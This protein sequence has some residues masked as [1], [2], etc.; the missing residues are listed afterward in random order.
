MRASKVETNTRLMVT[1]LILILHAALYML[2]RFSDK[3]YQALI[4]LI[5]TSLDLVCSSKLT[6]AWL[7]DVADVVI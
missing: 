1:I 5:F 4:T 2:L 6:L 7:H 3:S